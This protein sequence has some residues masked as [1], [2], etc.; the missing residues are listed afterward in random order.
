M[1]DFKRIVGLKYLKG[2][3]LNDSKERLN[4][5]KDRHEC[6]GKGKIGMDAFEFIM[7]SDLF[8]NIPLILETP[9]PK[10]YKNEI[11]ILRDFELDL[12]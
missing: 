1:E 8:E 6:L 11:K 7:K 3:H 10:E 5:K 2:M 4:S 12:N 9:D